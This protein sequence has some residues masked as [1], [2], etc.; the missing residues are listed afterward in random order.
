MFSSTGA[1]LVMR[2]IREG[3]FLVLILS[4][5]PLLASLIIG[6]VIGAH[7]KDAKRAW[8]VPMEA[9]QHRMTIN[10]ALVVMRTD[11]AGATW[12]E[13]RSGLPQQDAWDFPYRHALDVAPDGTTLAFGTTSGNFYVSEDGGDHCNCPDGEERLGSGLSP[14][15]PGHDRTATSGAACRGVGAELAM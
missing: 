2:V 3:L 10:G 9:D 6:F 14:G 12:K 4:A 7:P 15:E 11:D 8:I 1:D 13:Q 5:P